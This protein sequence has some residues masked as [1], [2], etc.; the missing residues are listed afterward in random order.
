VNYDPSLY[1]DLLS[2]SPVERRKLL[3]RSQTIVEDVLDVL[4]SAYLSQ[5]FDSFRT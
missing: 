5:P 4:L 3:L 2:P 1:L